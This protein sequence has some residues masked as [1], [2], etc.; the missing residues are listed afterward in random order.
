MF[1][2]IPISWA[3]FRRRSGR[4]PGGDVGIMGEL[5]VMIERLDSEGVLVR[6][7]HQPDTIGDT[8][9]NVV[10]SGVLMLLLDTICGFAVMQKMVTPV[11]IATLD[12]RV[13][14][15][16]AV[17]AGEDIFATGSCYRYG[18]N[19]GFSKGIVFTHDPDDPA[20]IGNGSFMLGT[21]GDPPP[22]AAAMRGRAR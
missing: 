20:A 11:A 2:D 22:M 12:L 15:L 19:V 1:D 14:Y 10:H 3:E 7:P 6:L 4:A 8:Q 9:W 5:G 18:R 17:P 13:D 21:A 16:R